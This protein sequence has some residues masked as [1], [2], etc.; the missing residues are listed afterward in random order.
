MTDSVLI[1]DSRNLTDYQWR[2]Y[3]SQFLFSNQGGR[4]QADFRFDK[5]L[6]CGSPT[7]NVT[8]SQIAFKFKKFVEREDYLPAKQS[9]VDIVDNAHLN[10]GE[11]FSTVW[12]KAFANWITDEVIDEE[13]YRNL[14]LALIGV[15]VCTL[16][17]IV[18]F[19]ACMWI[20]VSV[21]LTLVNSSFFSFTYFT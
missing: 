3:L 16:V 11:G 2:H 15:M 21:L 9:I 13:I 6:K 10:S 14:A 8:V 17:I 4:Y 5:E 20:F 7:P 12:G 19:Q 1:L 18:N